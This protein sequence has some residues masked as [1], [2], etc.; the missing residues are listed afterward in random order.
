MPWIKL[1]HI[2]ALLFWCGALLYLPALILH[3]YG[4]GK[5]ALSFQPHMPPIPRMVF[6]TV[7]TPAALLAI[8]SGTLLF[9]TYALFGGW[10]VLK[11]MAVVGMVF[12]HIICGWLITR[13]EQ[14][15]LAWMKMTAV[16]V[17]LFAAL[18]ML[19]V[20]TLVIA[21]PMN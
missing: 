20:I 8:I 16:A 15:K 1:V 14:G 6:T 19:T 18:C 2:V 21:K 17:T 5:S 3:E 9:L 13:L 12:A 4:R 11:L 7:A 10:L